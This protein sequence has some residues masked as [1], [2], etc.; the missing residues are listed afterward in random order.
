M[1]TPQR[2]KEIDR[3]FAAA[4]ELDV[5]ERPVFLAQACDGDHQLRDEVESLLAHVVP[6]SFIGGP[7]VEEATRLLSNEISVGPNSIGPYQVVKLLGAGGM[8]KV[9][10][11]HDPRLNRPVAVKLLSS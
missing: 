4:L 8:G 3:I 11:A 6:E 9:F 7:L 1:T 5:D 10:L 2:W